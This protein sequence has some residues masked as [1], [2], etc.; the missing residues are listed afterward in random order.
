MQ[1]LGP[2]M[3]ENFGDTVPSKP[4]QVP[5]GVSVVGGTVKAGGLE[6]SGEGIH[7]V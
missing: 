3:N 4:N 5:N 2:K 1:T 6:E 7:A